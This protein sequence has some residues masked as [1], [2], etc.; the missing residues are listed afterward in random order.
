M[1]PGICTEIYTFKFIIDVGYYYMKI[2]KKD[3]NV[4]IQSCLFNNGIFSYKCYE[5]ETI[6]IILKSMLSCSFLL[7]AGNDCKNIKSSTL[8]SF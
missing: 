4:F 7:K 6:I 3:C 1:W 5:A 8:P 2:K